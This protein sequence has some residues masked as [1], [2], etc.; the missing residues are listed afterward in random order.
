VVINIRGKL[1]NYPSKLCSL[2]SDIT[3]ICGAGVNVI[4]REGA[5]VELSAWQARFPESAVNGMS[6]TQCN[7][8][9]HAQ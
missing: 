2:H 3:L 8:Q 6:Y 5:G 1:L 9:N 7:S 4:G